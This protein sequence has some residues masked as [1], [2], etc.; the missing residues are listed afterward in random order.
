MS[1]RFA[2]LAAVAMV[3]AGCDDSQETGGTTGPA[4]VI[5]TQ[6]YERSGAYIEGAVWFVRIEGADGKLIFARRVEPGEK[7]SVSA[8]VPTGEYT[9][10]SYQRP[11]EANCDAGL[12]PPTDRCETQLSLRPG[13]AVRMTVHL[14]PGKGC[15]FTRP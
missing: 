10:V 3:V 5:L 14:Q 8:T 12:D 4:D 11:C 2:L 7:Q 9:L 1:S 15:T 13:D 6:A